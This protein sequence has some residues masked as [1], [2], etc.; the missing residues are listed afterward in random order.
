[1]R[2]KRISIVVP[3]Y[4]EEKNVGLLYE[5][6]AE[7]AS[8]HGKYIFEF[9]FIDNA[10]TDD[11]VAIL[12]NIAATDKQ[13]KIIVNNR[14][15]GPVRSPYW[16]L[17]QSKGDASIYMAADFQDP[18]DL[19]PDLISKWEHGSKIVLATKPVSEGN[20]L[21]HLIRRLYYFLLTKFSDIDLVSDSTGYG[22]YDKEVVNQLRLINDPYPYF[23]GLV[24]EFGYSISTID[25]VQPRR[26]R[27]VSKNNFFSLY[28]FAMLGI[29]SHSVLPIRLAAIL[30]F[31]VG[32][33]SFVL[34]L[35]VLCAK[36]IWWG[37][38][39]GGQASMLILIFLMFGTLLIFIG[40]L[41]EY[42][43]SIH[44]QLKNRPIVVEKERVNF[45]N[46]KGD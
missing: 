44:H 20:A 45:N 8:Q 38:F 19:L 32:F 6:F 18:P 39:S 11:T 31:F 24:Q 26:L 29:I 23:R 12:K 5:K 25:Y 21:M 41:G 15:F 16:G 22:I 3:T 30:G 40:M 13:V 27:G 17:L 2:R 7:L 14:N 33:S 46:D 43:G 34:A 35:I 42:V 10:S 36:L 28:D 9:L 37:S 4:N 1:M